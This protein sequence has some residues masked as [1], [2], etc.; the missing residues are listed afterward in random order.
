MFQGC[1]GKVPAV[2][3]GMAL[4]GYHSVVTPD[5]LALSNEAEGDDH[6]ELYLNAVV[7]IDD[8]VFARF[9]KADAMLPDISI[10]FVVHALDHRGSGFRRGKC[11]YRQKKGKRYNGGGDTGGHPRHMPQ[12]VPRLK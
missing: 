9:R 11:S 12:P 3:V 6:Q 1:V 7:D 4:I 10:G 5:L 2:V 8:Q